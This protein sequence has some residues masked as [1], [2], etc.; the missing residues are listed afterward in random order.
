MTGQRLIPLFA[1]LALAA[2]AAQ[3]ETRSFTATGPHGGTISGSGSCTALAG[4]GYS[5]AG[6]STTV[7][8]NGRTVLRQRTA[9]VTAEGAVRTRTAEG[10]RGSREVTRERSR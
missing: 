4:G 5:C 9:T 10:P 3:A 6:Q 8:P 1:V 2:G 7:R